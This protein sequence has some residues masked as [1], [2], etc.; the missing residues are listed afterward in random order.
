MVLWSADI[1]M[2]LSLLFLRVFS[3]SLPFFPIQYQLVVHTPFPTSSPS[4]NKYL[5]CCFG[6][7]SDPYRWPCIPI[8]AK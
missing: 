4:T 3:P 2:Y 5:A 6:K 1:S 7:T 8:E